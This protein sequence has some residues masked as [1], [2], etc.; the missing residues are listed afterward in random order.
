MLTN[1]DSMDPVKKAALQKEDDQIEYVAG[2]IEQ[3]IRDTKTEGVG[4]TPVQILPDRETVV[5]RDQISEKRREEFAPVI[6][7]GYEY[8]ADNRVVWSL[9]PYHYEMVRQGKVCH[10]CLEWQNDIATATCSWRGKTE[11]C[12]AE[13]LAHA[14]AYELFG[15][16]N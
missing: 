13:S 16:K 7:I 14:N 4:S 6:P 12:G 8:D 1:A 9:S 5:T 3:R 11:G 2:Q 10:A 15:R